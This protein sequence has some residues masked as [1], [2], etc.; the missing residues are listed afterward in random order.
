MTTELFVH[1]INAITTDIYD[2][3]A[4]HVVLYNGQQVSQSVI[5]CTHIEKTIYS[6]WKETNNKLVACYTI[7]YVLSSSG[8]KWS[9]IYSVLMKQLGLAA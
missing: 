7:Q 2:L 3:Q 8:Q 9:F 1:V 4:H 6:D 5:W